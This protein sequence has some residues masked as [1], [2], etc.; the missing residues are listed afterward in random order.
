MHSVSVPSYLHGALLGLRHTAELDAQGCELQSEAATV[1]KP[2]QKPR[3]DG[4]Y[5]EE[6]SDIRGRIQVNHSAG[7]VQSCFVQAMAVSHLSWKQVL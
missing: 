7:F 1:V 3:G 2:A 4:Q 5:E 6:L